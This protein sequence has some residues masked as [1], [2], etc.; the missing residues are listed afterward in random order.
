MMV[1]V[2]LDVDTETRVLKFFPLREKVER[3]SPANLKV[4]SPR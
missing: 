3:V 2:G 4:V 1:D